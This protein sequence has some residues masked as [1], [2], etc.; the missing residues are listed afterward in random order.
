MQNSL[1]QPSPMM[2]SGT[3][4]HSY[5]GV[6]PPEL[7]KP[8]SSLAF[9]QTS[10]TQHIPILFET[11]LNQPSGMGGSQL[12]DTHIL[13]VK[14]N[15]RIE[16]LNIISSSGYRHLSEELT[17]TCTVITLQRQGMGQH[18]NLYSGQVQQHT[19]NSYYSSTQSP[20]SAL[21]QVCTYHVIFFMCVRTTRLSYRVQYNVLIIHTAIFSRWQFPCLAPSCHCLALAL[22]G[23]S[24]CWPF[25][26]LCLLPHL[27]LSLPAWTAN[28]QAASHIVA[29]LA[30]TPTTWC[31]L[32]TRCVHFTRLNHDCK[33]FKRLI[34]VT[35]MLALQ[36]VNAL[37]VCDRCAIWT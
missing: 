14:V 16:I 3:A 31:N 29:S 9:Q 25:H 26:S 28:P 4:L 18:S 7:A 22:V 8:Q 34:K 15:S 2:L 17:W 36:Q 35:F 10:N 30:R 37:F 33:Y 6:Q 1:S 21:Q 19:Q 27:R 23:V 13:Q 32:L 24:P 20:S 5:P 12:I 11:Q